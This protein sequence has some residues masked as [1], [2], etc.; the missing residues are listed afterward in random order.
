MLQ[1]IGKIE[2]IALLVLIIINQII[3]NLADYI[4]INTGSSAWI[5]VIY[6]SI[7]AILVCLLIYKLFKPFNN[8]DI[9]DISRFLGGKFLEI[10]VGVLYILFFLFISFSALRYFVNSLKLI[11]FTSTPLV[12]LLLLFLIPIIFINKYGIKVITKVNLIFMP[13]LLF[14][15]L[16]VFFSTIKGLVPQ[17]IFPLLGYGVNKTFFEGITNVFA[18]S[19]ISYLYFLIPQLKDQNDF[20]KIA[21]VS[22]IISSLILLLNV[23]CLLLFFSFIY[24]TDE[25]LTLYIL[26][27]RIEYGNFLQ[28]ID[29]LFIF[30]W[31]VSM[32]TY[33]SIIFSYTLYIF[34]KLTKIKNSNQMVYSLGTLIFRWCFIC[35]K[36]S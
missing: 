23:V 6:T 8:S 36:Y 4:I 2:A 11:Y 25:M 24:E 32:L 17:R 30:F 28:R 7:I 13:I 31:I 15:I 10:V 27:R 1:R 12:F 35:E 33:L 5:N 20:K 21:I 3:L 16:L 9:L 14:S 29:A 22:T 19:N 26:S 18:F 34:K